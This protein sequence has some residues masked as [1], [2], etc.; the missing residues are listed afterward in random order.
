MASDVRLRKIKKILEKHCGKSNQISAGAIGP[1]IG[2]DEDATHVQARG[3]ILRTIEELNL[4]V[5]AGSRGYYLI[6]DKN[7]LQEYISSIDGRIR[8]MEKGRTWSKMFLKIT[9]NA[10]H[11]PTLQRTQ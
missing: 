4:P 8:E 5:A 1:Q 9:I 10:E 3:L 6:K 7:E 2:I 11:N